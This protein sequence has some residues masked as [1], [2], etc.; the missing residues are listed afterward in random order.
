MI[1]VKT[2]QNVVIDYEYA[3]GYQRVIAFIVDAII[4]WISSL[5]LVFIAE[6]FR[7]A[8]MLF[9]VIAMCNGFFYTLWQENVFKGRTVG[10]MILGIKVIKLDGSRPQFSDYFLRWIFRG[11]EGV[12]SF[13][14]IAVVLFVVSE[15]RQRLGDMLAS[16]TVVSTRF[17]EKRLSLAK[18]QDFT[19]GKTYEQKFEHINRFSEEEMVLIKSCLYRKGKHKNEAHNKLFNDMVKRIAARLELKKLPTKTKEQFV[20]DVIKDYVLVNR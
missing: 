5:I 19:S 4:I 6:L 12:Y 20:K 18:I 3:E 10:K 8:E 16:T 14:S 2:P 9:M 1:S 15:K 13:F 17:N 7:S 11:I